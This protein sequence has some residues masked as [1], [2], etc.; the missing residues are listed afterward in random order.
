REEV[1][2]SAHVCHPSLANDNLS[3]IA[4]ATFLAQ[5]LA[6]IDRHY[7]YR[8]VFA[9]STIGVI[10][11]LAQRE[12]VTA[13]IRLGLAI[14]GAGDAGDYNSTRSRRGVAHIDGVMAYVLGQSGLA[15]P[16]NPF[17]P[18]GYDERQYCSPG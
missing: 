6:R 16:V 4:V 1:L 5:A 8:F 11:W 18:Y 12:A 2:I 13:R 14:S 9:P 15:R 7:T 3:S 17:V 10:T